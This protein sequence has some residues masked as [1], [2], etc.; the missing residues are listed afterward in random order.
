MVARRWVGV[1][2]GAFHVLGLDANGGV[3]AWGVD[4]DGKADVPVAATNLEPPS[5]RAA[6]SLPWPALRREA[7]GVGA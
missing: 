1:S 4:R 7:A 3:I 5:P 6:F 2:A